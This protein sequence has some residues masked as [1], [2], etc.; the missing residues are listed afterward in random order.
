[1]PSAA[2]LVFLGAGTGG[3]L[4]YLLTV[5]AVALAGPDYPWGTLVINTLGC[6]LIGVCSVTLPDGAGGTTHPF[7]FLLMTGVLGGFTTYS[8]F[9][10]EAAALWERGESVGAALYAGGTLALCLVAVAAGLVLARVATA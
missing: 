3:V 4:R 2:L 6:F 5:A 7:R 8:S 9:S 10:L 1:M